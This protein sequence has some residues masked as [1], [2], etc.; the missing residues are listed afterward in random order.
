[1]KHWQ[2]REKT[3][4]YIIDA[5]DLALCDLVLDIQYRT[6]IFW[7]YELHRLY[8][9]NQLR[10]AAKQCRRTTKYQECFR[11]LPD[12][13]TTEQFAKIFGYANNRAGQKSLQRLEV[14]NAIKRTMRGH[15]KKLVSELPTT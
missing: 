14:D 11:M 3:G 5:Q 1:M 10:D 4:T 12:E 15:Y 8:Y 13:F 7:Y 9:D 2:E 6:Q